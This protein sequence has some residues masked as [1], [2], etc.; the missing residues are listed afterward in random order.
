MRRTHAES[1]I[2]AMGDRQTKQHRKREYVD[3]HC[4]DIEFRTLAC[5]TKEE[6]V[7]RE[8]E[9]KFGG[10]DYLFSEI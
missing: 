9:L 1:R 5:E 6:A 7:A 10:F 4:R 2:T 3:K 8:R